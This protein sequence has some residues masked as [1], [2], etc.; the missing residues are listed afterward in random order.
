[1]IRQQLDEGILTLV[2]DHPPVNAFTI[3][4]LAEMKAILDSIAE[5]A[6]VRVVVIRAEG[7]GFCAGGDVK[8]VERLPGFEGILGQTVGSTGS[9]ALARC[10][11][12]VICAVHGYCI[13]A[14]VLIV[15]M[16]DIVVAAQG[17]R[18]IL[19]EIDNGATAGGVQ[20]L[21]LMPEKRVRLAMMTAQPVFA[22][23]LF[24]YGSV[25]Q[26]VPVEK[27][28]SAAQSIALAIAAKQPESMRRMKKSLNGITGIDALEMRYRSEI[29]YT[30]ELNIMGVASE[31]RS[32]FIEGDRASY[33]PPEA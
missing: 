4:L 25:A 7:R 12:P 6:D 32:T 13:G 30:Y 33:M 24:G 17:T 29:S 2:I 16:A 3:G 5:R 8:E 23:E 31:G 26:V 15:G 11:V 22:E 9:I 20:A 19:A 21:K 1:M 14:G 10:A 27:L 18:F 28:A